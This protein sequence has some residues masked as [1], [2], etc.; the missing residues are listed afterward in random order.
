VVVPPIVTFPVTFRL[1]LIFVVPLTVRPVNVGVSVRV[2]VAPIPD[3]VA[4]RLPLT[5]L[6]SFTLP[7]VP[8]SEPSSR[9]EIPKINPSLA[10]ETP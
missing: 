2:I 4:V 5:K 1:E 8:T 6:I 7:A 3:A 9:I 10:P